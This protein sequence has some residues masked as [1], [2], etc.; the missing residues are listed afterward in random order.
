MISQISSNI[1]TKQLYLK[2]YIYVYIY[3]LTQYLLLKEVESQRK[4]YESANSNS[5]EHD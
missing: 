1:Y 3:I 2:R 4:E 5:L